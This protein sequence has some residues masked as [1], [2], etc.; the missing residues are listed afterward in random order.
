MVIYLALICLSCFV[1]RWYPRYKLKFSYG[2]DTMFHLYYSSVIRENNMKTPE[3]LPGCLPTNKNGYPYLYHKILALLPIGSVHLMERITGALFDTL[4]V[5]LLSSF[6]IYNQDYFILTEI[7]ILIIAFL[8]SWSPFLLRFDKGPRAFCG[9]PRVFS[10]FIYTVHILAFTQFTISLDS[11]FLA[12]SIFFGSLI[13]IS[14][15]F[16]IQVLFFFAIFLSILEPYYIYPLVLALSYL[17]SIIFSK[18]KVFRITYSSY[19]H[20]EYVYK[21]TMKTSI[22]PTFI[23]FFNYLGTLKHHMLSLLKNGNI[24]KFS[25][26]LLNEKYVAHVI[27]INYPYLIGTLIM[28]CCVNS[29]S[30]FSQVN[31][32]IVVW[33]FS[34]IFF[35]ILSSIKPFIFL[36]NGERYLEYSLIPI[37]IMLIKVINVEE[38]YVLYSIL[39]IYCFAMSLYYVQLFMKQYKEIEDDYHNEQKIFKFIKSFPREGRIMPVPM[40]LGNKIMYYTGFEVLR[41]YL[42]QNNKTFNFEA[43]NKLFGGN[44]MSFLSGDLEY[45]KTTYNVQFIIIKK[46]FLHKFEHHIIKDIKYFNENFSLIKSSKKLLLYKLD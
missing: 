29:Q 23:S 32:S 26:W 46:D 12:I 17:V 18:G 8:Y 11:L 15:I 40:Y 4:T 33:F 5:I 9:T 38:N 41:P 22:Y 45:L 21:H 34:A 6:L 44:S 42:L 16:G 28:L 35:T 31:L 25:E 14:T 30:V 20:I 7:E 36:G 2:S 43:L 39:L 13:Y 3:Y 37:L 24:K 19:K 1:I 10:L 27:V